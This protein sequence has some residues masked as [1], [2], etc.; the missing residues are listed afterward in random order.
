MALAILCAVKSLQKVF[1]VEPFLQKIN[2]LFG[3]CCVDNKKFLHLLF[4]PRCRIFDHCAARGSKP[5][6]KQGMK[7]RCKN[8]VLSMQHIPKRVFIFCQKVKQWKLFDVNL[9]HFLCLCV[10]A[11]YTV[12]VSYNFDSDSI[13]VLKSKGKLDKWFICLISIIF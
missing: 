11:Y 10:R 5:L 9:R 13:S 1:I 2:I 7:R 8:F 12:L 4:I 3:S 6:T